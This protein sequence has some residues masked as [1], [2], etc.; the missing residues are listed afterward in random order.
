MHRALISLCSVSL[1]LS[2]T[3]CH[4][5]SASKSGDAA[6][7]DYMA[8]QKKAELFVPAVGKTGGEIILST[9]S[10]PKS[11]NPI[12]ATETS[13]SEF[14]QYMYEGLV[15]INGV[16]RLPEPSLARSWDISADGLTWTFHL[17]PGILWSDSVPITAADVE[18]TFNQ[19]IYN[20]D[21]NPCSSR[22]IF[23]IN[24]KPLNVAALDSATV[25]FKLPVP[26]APFL[27]SLSQEIL[28]HHIW[29]P[30]VKKK[31]FAQALGIR[32]NPD[33]MVVSGPFCLQSYISSQKVVFKRN[34]HYWQKDSTGNQL[35]YLDRVI[36]S[37]VQDQNAEL[38]AFKRGDIDF[39]AA[40]G[41]D[42]PGLKKDEANGSFTVFRLGPNTGANFLFF[43]QN[44]GRDS[45]T[46]KPF[47]DSVKLSWFRNVTFRKAM[48]YAL[49]KESMIRIVMN[50]LGYPQWSPMTPAEGYFYNPSVTTYLY[51]IKEAK[52]LLAEAGF[53]DKNNDSILEDKEG[54]PLEFSFC[55]NSG[56][57]VRLKIAEIIRKDLESIGCKI[58]FQQLEFNSIIAK[59]SNKPYEWDAVLLGLTGGSEPHF[60]RNV[61]HSSGNLHMWFPSQSKPS[62]TWETSIDSIFDAG[63]VEL[64]VVKRKALYDQ[65]QS[66]AADNVPL[67]YT[68]LAEQIYCI[69]NRIKNI[70]PSPN[71]GILHNI[72]RLYVETGAHAR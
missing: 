54:H 46:G 39:L 68:V 9:F 35:P 48:A 27:R 3:S 55:T 34:P 56:N 61:W 6:P 32:T 38:L 16:S 19:L 4:K 57:N 30:I 17:R 71:G 43:N 24:N 67:I 40:K 64:D 29:A 58:H 22:D 13:T 28:P 20:N 23:L 12:T 10:D 45:A 52:R 63:V 7:V 72:E 49:D 2:L 1:L 65:W 33:S 15:R 70:N 8:I 42:F 26:F 31:T 5:Q 41:E 53:F 62:S 36:Y 25:Q 37:I 11:F 66:S 21:I 50:G 60:G 18:F 69:N 51:N 59:I 14:T 47:V 44:T